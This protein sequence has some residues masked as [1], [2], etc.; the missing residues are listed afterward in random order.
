[1]TGLRVK[2]R[3]PLSRRDP[4]APRSENRAFFC[5]LS[6][7]MRRGTSVLRSHCGGKICKD[8]QVHL[9]RCCTE[10]RMAASG[11]FNMTLRFAEK[12][13]SCVVWAGYDG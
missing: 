1:M 3:L 6:L 7:G 5:R 12:K 10:Q 8:V 11:C 9:G 2:G 4:A 13:R